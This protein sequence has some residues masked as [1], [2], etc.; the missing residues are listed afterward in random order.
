MVI[1]AGL[2]QTLPADFALWMGAETLAYLDVVI[3]V[4]FVASMTKVG[5]LLAYLRVR[6][7]GLVR[8]VKRRARRSSARRLPSPPDEEGPAFALA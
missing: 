6:S 8:R 5:P 4:A 7:T 1:V 2:A 3:G